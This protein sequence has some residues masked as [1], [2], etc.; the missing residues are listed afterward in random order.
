M[1]IAQEGW[2]QRG[3]TKQFGL[4]SLF[5]QILFTADACGVSTSPEDKVTAAVNGTIIAKVVILYFI[6]RV[7]KTA[8]CYIRI[9]G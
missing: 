3:C 6:F 4:L 8:Y 7:R 9:L 1:N 2:P 5:S